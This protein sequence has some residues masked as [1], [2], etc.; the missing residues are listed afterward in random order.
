MG[1]LA[2]FAVMSLV[3]STYAVV[4][5]G[6]LLLGVFFFGDPVFSVMMNSLSRRFPHWQEEFDM[7]KYYTQGPGLFTDLLLLT[8]ILGSF[9]MAYRPTRSL[10]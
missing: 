2:F 7:K 8:T 3:F 4:K 5:T 10:V 6:T 1:L 9:W